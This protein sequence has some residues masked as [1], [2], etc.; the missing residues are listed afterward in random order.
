MTGMLPQAIDSCDA[1]RAYKLGKERWSYNQLK[2][3]IHD[4]AQRMRLDPK[5]A[6]TV[7]MHQRT[8]HIAAGHCFRVSAE[9][10]PSSCSVCAAQRTLCSCTSAALMTLPSQQRASHA[11]ALAVLTVK[12]FSG[13]QHSCSVTRLCAQIDPKRLPVRQQGYSA[14]FEME[15]MNGSRLK[16]VFFICYSTPHRIATE[17]GHKYEWDLVTR[18]HCKNGCPVRHSPSPP[19]HLAPLTILCLLVSSGQK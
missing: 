4:S 15:F 18:D 17:A 6:K 3:E 16:I 19:A 7:S 11:A 13:T 14:A 5:L 2:V 8:L 12:V 9:T 10:T 1:C